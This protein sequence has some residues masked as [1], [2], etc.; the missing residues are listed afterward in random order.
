MKLKKIHVLRFMVVIAVLCSVLLIALFGCS[1][2]AE[3]WVRRTIQSYYYRFDGDYSSISDLDGLSVAQMMEKLDPYSDFY[4]A[5]EYAAIYADNSGSKSGVGITYTYE[6]SGVL[7]RSVVG[8]SPSKKAGLKAGDIVISG[9]AGEERVQFTKSSDFSDFVNRRAT[10][11]NFNLYLKDG[12]FV[13]LAKTEYTASYASMY[14][15]KCSYE[16]EYTGKESRIVKNTEQ[17]IPQ[18]PEGAAYIYLSQF[19]GGAADEIAMLVSVFNQNNC[20]SL[21]LDLRDNGGGYVDLMSRIGGR[22]TSTVV[23]SA[24]STVAKYKDGSEYIEYCY[25]YSQDVV[26]AG[27]DVYLMANYN[28][29][30]ASEA[31]IGVLVSYNILKYENIF[32]SKYEGYEAKSFGKGIMQSTFKNNSTGDV[33]KLTVAG[34]YWAN[35][36]TV[37]DRGVTVADGCVAAPAS[38]NVVNVG[39]D[40]ELVPVIE[41]IISD[42]Q[43]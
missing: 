1:S 37:H 10:G 30:S 35:G 11:E 24:V 42:R 20:T 17:G 40:D 26:P 23:D 19:Y 5:D 16:I 31:L 32:L 41:K 18:L 43:Q 8:N 15:N 34:I 2:N 39:Y 13:T 36:V 7:I 28:T 3:D 14:T 27:T 38:D 33:L 22:F 6:N 4:T 21:I 9:S 25:G 29:A 12:N